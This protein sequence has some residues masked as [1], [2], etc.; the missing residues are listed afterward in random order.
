MISTSCKHHS[1][2]SRRTLASAVL[3]SLVSV[4]SQTFFSKKQKYC[5]QQRHFGEIFNIPATF[6]H[7]AEAWCV[8]VRQIFNHKCV[9]CESFHVT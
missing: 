4:L 9:C 5:F 7:D 2:L 6:F 1:A 8:C 3:L